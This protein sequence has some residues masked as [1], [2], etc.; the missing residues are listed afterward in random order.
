MQTLSLLVVVLACVVVVSAASA[1]RTG[2][3]DRVITGTGKNDV[4]NGGA[5]AD[6]IYGHGGNDRLDGNG[7]NDTLHGGHGA[8]ALVGAGGNDTIFAADGERDA[9]TCGSGRDSAKVDPSDRV[10]ADCEQVARP[11]A[12]PS[13][14]PP[15]GSGDSGRVI[16]GTPRNDVLVGGPGNDRIYGE[17]GNDR[18]TGR[19]GNDVL[20]GGRG[21]DTIDAGPGNDTVD[22]ADGARDRVNC[23]PGREAVSADRMDVLRGCESS[24]NPPPPSPPPPPAPPAPPPPSPPPPASGSCSI[25]NTSGCAARS[26]LNYTNATW[27][28]DRPLSSYGALPLRVVLD[29]TNNGTSFGA[30]LDAGCTGD[31]NASTIDLILDIRGDGRTR[32]PSEDAIRIMNHSPGARDIQITGRADCGPR[33]GGAHQDGIQAI[34]GTNI[35][36]VDFVIGNYDAGVATCQGAGGIVFYS[37]DGGTRPQNLQIIRGSYIGCN[38]ALG[39]GNP[40]NSTG[41]ARDAR[42]RTGRIVAQQ[43][44]CVDENGNPYHSS[45]PCITPSNFTRANLTCQRWNATQQQWENG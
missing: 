25:A 27:T 6:T 37:G 28:C 2:A 45:P 30:R 38:H 18:I 17:G 26:T 31:G 4:L 44:I 33:R 16:R 13:P 22:V 5:G 12:A 34:G 20:V 1:T 7:G 32:G 41:A 8:D 23:G 9:I 36:F 42:F 19:G 43:G 24:S 39:N 3:N 40:P 15:S 11:A 14:Q 29:Y 35:T 21:Q 10:A